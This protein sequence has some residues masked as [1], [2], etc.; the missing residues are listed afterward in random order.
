M[1]LLK[2]LIAYA[3][4]DIPRWVATEMAKIEYKRREIEKGAL[5]SGTQHI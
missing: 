1:I 5:F 3:I 4:P 2:V